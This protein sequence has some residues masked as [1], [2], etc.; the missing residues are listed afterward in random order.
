MQNKIFHKIVFTKNVDIELNLKIYYVGIE[1]VS[2]E[3]NYFNF[4]SILKKNVQNG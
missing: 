4:L 1:Q 3:C 2:I